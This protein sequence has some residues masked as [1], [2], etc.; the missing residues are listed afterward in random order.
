MLY[1][2]AAYVVMRC[3]S[4]CV[5]VSVCVSVTFVNSAKTNKQTY[6]QNFFTIG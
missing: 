5:C 6:H 2:S 1:A 4:A 3:L